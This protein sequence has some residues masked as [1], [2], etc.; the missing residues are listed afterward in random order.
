MLEEIIKNTVKYKSSS[1]DKEQK[2]K[3][4]FFTGIRTAE[5]MAGLYTPKT[6]NIKV[7]DPGA[8][9]GLL[10][11][12]LVEK[13]MYANR[14]DSLEITF[15][16]NDPKI[17]PTLKKTA[18]II[19]RHCKDRVRCKI[20][21]IQENFILADIKNTFDVVICNPPYMKI[22]K[23][24]PES[25]AMKD[26][27]Y[28]QPNLYALFMAKAANL[29]QTDGAFIFITPRSWASGN[30][31]SVVR[32]YLAAN[33]SYKEIHIFNSRDKAFT[34]EAVLQETMIIS[35]IKNTLQHKTI[36]ITA[37]SD[38]S[39]ATVTGFSV[40]SKSIKWV[41]QG[42]CLLIPE[43][44]SEAALIKEMSA[45]KSTFSS[46]GYIFKTG[47]VV[48]FRNRELL[49]KENTPDTIPMYRALNITNGSLVFPINSSKAQYIKPAAKPLLIKNEKLETN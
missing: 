23:D 36:H 26:F 16:E 4:Q 14:C 48:E 7:L 32:R 18:N 19:K 3:G 29:L 11:A 33:L 25:K 15:I 34:T 6:R 20:S 41:G 17:I 12:A 47:P 24:S 1:S 21:F 8:G 42:E 22:R 27:V 5:F 31:F 49:S 45:I 9:N 35:A 43:N 28:G 44:A 38:D 37:S 46:L 30:Y 40:P 39:F 13:L 10:A 2:A